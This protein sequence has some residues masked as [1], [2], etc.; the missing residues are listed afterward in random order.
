MSSPEKAIERLKLLLMRYQRGNGNFLE[1]TSRT[2]SSWAKYKGGN[3]PEE[4]SRTQLLKDAAN[5]NVK[6]DELF[7]R[8]MA[9]GFGPAGYARYRTIRILDEVE[10]V[11]GRTIDSW[12]KSL[13]SAS[14]KSEMDGFKFLGSTDGKINFLGP[15]FATKSLYFL[16]PE[17]KRAPI[18][19]SV[20]VSWLRRYQIATEKEPISLEF[21]K[22]E[23]YKR[24]IEFVDDALKELRESLGQRNE[25][26]R[27]FIEY[28]IFQDQRAYQSDLSL[29][30]WMRRTEFSIDRTSA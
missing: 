19:D 3:F 21:A 25:N 28:L 6:L 30:K 22:P 14:L 16:S 20:V 15:A 27:G 26:D 24:Y 29:E 9:W 11:D 7:V 13:R 17:G 1:Q 23:G 5:Q 2:G 18:L 12:M 8:I 4:I 10:A